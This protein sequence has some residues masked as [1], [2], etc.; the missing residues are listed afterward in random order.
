MDQDRDGGQDGAPGG[1]EIEE[2]EE[3]EDPEEA[4]KLRKINEQKQ[5]IAEQLKKQE[6]STSAAK[7]SI[8]EM[9]KQL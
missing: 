2:I 4:E 9:K 1:E 8:E 3:V 5:S 6:E 7:V